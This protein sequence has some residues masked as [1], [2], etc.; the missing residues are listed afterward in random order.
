LTFFEIILCRARDLRP[1]V[2][3]FLLPRDT[4]LFSY[5]SHLFLGATLPALCRV[6]IIILFSFFFPEP[7]S[8]SPRP[9]SLCP[10]YT[11]SLISRPLSFFTSSVGLLRVFFYSRLFFGFIRLCSRVRRSMAILPPTEAYGSAQHLSFKVSFL[12]R[13][14]S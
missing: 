10:D 5:A 8:F 12:G 14:H 6:G 3:S 4:Y 13:D 1:R 2:S 7:T 9:C 11:H